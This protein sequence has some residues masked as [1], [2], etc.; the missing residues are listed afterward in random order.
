MAYSSVILL[1][2]EI[3]Y[4]FFVACFAAMFSQGSL[5]VYERGDDAFLRNSELQGF[6]TLPNIRYS[7]N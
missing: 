3:I 5:F 2:T 1:N 7:R 4:Q 6:F